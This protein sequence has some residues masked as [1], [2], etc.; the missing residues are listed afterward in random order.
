MLSLRSR[1][2]ED[3]VT[4][5]AD[6]PDSQNNRS[7]DISDNDFRVKTK[8]D[9]AARD[10]RE[11]LDL[12]LTDSPADSLANSP[13][14]SV[15]HSPQFSPNNTAD[16]QRIHEQEGPD[17][18]NL[19]LR[20]PSPQ[21]PTAERVPSPIPQ[22]TPSRSMFERIKSV[23]L[24]SQ[25]I[26]PSPSSFSS[27]KSPKANGSKS[28]SPIKPAALNTQFSQG[29]W[30]SS[31]LSMEGT[32]ERS[33]SPELVMPPTQAPLSP[34]FAY[35]ESPED[36][37]TSSRSEASPLSQEIGLELSNPPDGESR[38]PNPLMG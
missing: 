32:P 33:A 9:A 16:S 17:E 3:L 23:F 25:S 20:T 28:R 37:P 21:P 7:A 26:I 19:A 15:N 29:S 11:M 2:I 22:Q 8:L 24:S 36:A 34:A 30:A 35:I 18:Y 27:R 12:A 10:P 5:T 6:S 31:S 14:S 1:S 38:D 13:T 4:G